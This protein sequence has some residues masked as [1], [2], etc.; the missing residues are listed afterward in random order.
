MRVQVG[1]L[2]RNILDAARDV[3]GDR[4]PDARLFAEMELSRLARSGRDIE[5]LLLDGRI[6]ERRAR[7]LFEIYR[8]AARSALLSV[9]SITASTAAGLVD[10]ALGEIGKAVSRSTGIRFF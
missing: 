5:Q 8:V 3:A 7:E 2:V 10:A 9:E 6:D 4:W 1:T